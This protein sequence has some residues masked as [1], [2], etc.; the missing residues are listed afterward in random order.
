M[1]PEQNR[2]RLAKSQKALDDKIKAGTYRTKS[3][4]GFKGDISFERVIP[5]RV[6]K[7]TTIRNVTVNTSE[8][9]KFVRKK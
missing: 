9:I 6:P 1:T 5:V 2:K 4:A 8:T 3:L 7:T